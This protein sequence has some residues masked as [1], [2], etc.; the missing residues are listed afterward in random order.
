MAQHNTY[1]EIQRSDQRTKT[2]LPDVA[3]K[4]RHAITINRPR[5]EV[6]SFV[7]NFENLVKIL[8]GFIE[9]TNIS[10][11]ESRWTVKSKTGFELGWTAKITEEKPNEMISWSS[12]KS[13]D[14]SEVEIL[15]SVWF[16]DAPGGR[17][18]V[19]TLAMDYDILG[20]KAAEW[21]AFF[22][23]E[24]PDTLAEANLKRLKAY[25]ETGEIATTEGQPSGREE[26]PEELQH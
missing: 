19:I 12:L 3:A 6:Y 9:I 2:A 11:A 10:P 7:R 8:K 21:I 16:T 5:P 24:H 22:G 23:G 26:I 25:I 1:V 15:G 13:L 17:G 4:S 18:T 14:R 20:G